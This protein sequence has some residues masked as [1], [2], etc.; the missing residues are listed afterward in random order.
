[1]SDFCLINIGDVRAADTFPTTVVEKRDGITID[2]AEFIAITIHRVPVSALLDQEIAVSED[3]GAFVRITIHFTAGT[4]VDIP[5]A[6]TTLNRY[7]AERIIIKVLAVDA[8]YQISV[9][10]CEIPSIASSD[11]VIAVIEQVDLITI[12]DRT[13]VAID[14]DLVAGSLDITT[15]P[16][17]L[18]IIRACHR[19]AGR[20]LI[21]GVFEPQIILVGHDILRRHC[22]ACQ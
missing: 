3:I 1:M 16:K 14:I 4:M 19:F 9:F 11:T 21:S 15:V 5:I 22:Q 18:I 20:H 8:A 13:A 10:V 6:G 7:V 2:T 17:V 12:K